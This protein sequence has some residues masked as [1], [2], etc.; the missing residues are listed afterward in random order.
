MGTELFNTSSS[1]KATITSLEVETG[2]AYDLL[3]ENQLREGFMIHNSSDDNIYIAYSDADA[4]TTNYSYVIPAG[5][6]YETGTLFYTGKIGIYA[7]GD[8]TVVATALG[9]V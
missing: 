4:S 5:A 6:F 9:E 3:P 7:S 1:S 8:G 2:N